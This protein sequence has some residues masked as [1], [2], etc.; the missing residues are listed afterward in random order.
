M[1]KPVQDQSPRHDIEQRAEVDPSRK[2]GVV[3]RKPEDDPIRD[4]ICDYYDSGI[5]H[6]MN[7]VQMLLIILDQENP[8]YNS[9][10]LHPRYLSFYIIH[11]PSEKDNR[12][13]HD[14]S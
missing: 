8:P 4:Q 10:S 14:Y 1:E 12:K 7:P 11:Y 2:S 3:P 6:H 9:L 5:D 13:K